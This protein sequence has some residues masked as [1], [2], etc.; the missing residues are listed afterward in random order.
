MKLDP[1]MPA[2]MLLKLIRERKITAESLTQFYLK[3]IGIY[4]PTLRAVAEL[5]PSAL[6]DAHTLDV[7]ADPSRLPLF[8]LPIL[9]KDNIDVKG[10]HTTAETAALLDNIAAADAPVIS[11][12]RKK[13]AIILGKTNMTEFANYTTQGMPGGFSSAGGQVRHA[14]N[15]AADPSG[16]SSGSAVAVSAGL[17]AA[18]VGTDTSFSIVGCATVHGLASLKPPHDVLSAQGIIP[19]A[20]TLDSAGPIARTFDDALLLYSAMCGTPFS[21]PSAARPESLHIAVN[22]ANRNMVS[23]NQLALYEGLF[24][25]LRALGVQ[26]QEIDQP[27]TPYQKTVMRCEFRHDLETYLQ[28]TNAARRTLPEIIAFYKDNP[29]R[30]PYGISYLLDAVPIS[31]PALDPDYQEAIAYRRS[32]R[33]EIMEALKSFDACVMTGPTNIMHYTGLPSLSLPLCMG[34]DGLP[35]GIILYGADEMR[36]YASARTIEQFCRHVAPPEL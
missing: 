20:H 27:S 6:H 11:N 24:A 12:L 18:A 5:N 35:R 1:F 10:L 2:A 3:C 30:M 25:K 32:L 23:E 19:I 29:D 22:T 14:Y 34:A 17:C 28:G 16:S 8:G 26:F 21:I 31:D 4:N 9:V 15:P 36:L 33:T 7:S 13:G